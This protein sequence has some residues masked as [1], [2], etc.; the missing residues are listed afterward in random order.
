MIY[1]YRQIIEDELYDND[2]PQGGAG[3][4]QGSG[5]DYVA[6]INFENHFKIFRGLVERS[7]TYHY[8]FWNMLLDDS[9]DLMRL[10]D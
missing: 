10:K 1:R 9:P 3:W 4:A 8:D 5:L 6:A 2:G 7:T